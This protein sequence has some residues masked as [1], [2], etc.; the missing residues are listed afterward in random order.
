[1]R[2]VEQSVSWL[3]APPE[4]TLQILE[5]AGRTCYKSECHITP[6]SAKD[7]V[8]RIMKS[9]HESVIEHVS[10]SMKFITDRGVMA[11][12]RTHRLASFSVESTRYC[13]YAKDKFNK[14]CTFV[15]PIEFVE[16]A[17]KPAFSYVPVE[18]TQE[19]YWKW[20]HAMGEAE[21][22]Y[23]KMIELG[24]TPQLARSVLPNS[25]KTEIVCTA[26]MRE[27]RHIFKLRTSQQAHPQI[28]ELLT[29]ALGIMRE[30]VPVIF[31]EI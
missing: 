21:K 12:F 31:D 9:G 4:N 10:A 17:V 6:D 7:F 14:E 1:M 3:Q 23:M 11:E 29:K 25:L 13:N 30:R 2:I 16:Y 28:R 18:P 15:I 19:L 20:H 24:A 8:K 5:Q 22:S 27:W 26:N